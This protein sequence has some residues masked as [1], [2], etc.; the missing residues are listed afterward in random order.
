MSTITIFG[1]GNMGGAIAGVLARG[2]ASIQHIVSGDTDATIEGDLVVLAV[3]Y[4]AL[5]TIAATYG[6]QLTGKTVVD[7]TNPLNFETFDSLVV[8]V[9]SSAAA[10]L[11]KALPGARVLKAFNTKG[12]WFRVPPVRA[13]AAIRGNGEPLFEDGSL[14]EAMTAAEKNQVVKDF[15]GDRRRAEKKQKI[16][17]DFGKAKRNLLSIPFALAL[18]GAMYFFLKYV[19]KVGGLTH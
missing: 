17:R 14:V 7:I 1:N 11:Q 5:E 19:L 3:P 12:E 6:E 4:G 2:G 8:P 18:L 15:H 16:K 9:G 10:E 13:M